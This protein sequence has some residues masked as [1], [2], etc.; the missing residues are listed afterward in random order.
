MNNDLLYQRWCIDLDWYKRNNC[1]FLTLAQSALCLTCR[2][3]LKSE[4]KA[5]EILEMVAICCSKKAHFITRNMPVL[6]SLFR[7]FLKNRNQ[8][9]TLEGIARELG[10]CRGDKVNFSP[11]VLYRLLISD[12]YYGLQP[13]LEEVKLS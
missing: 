8:P 10:R 7:I 9:L 5:S 1:S 6:A 12:R 13:V 4:D 3:Q 11:E 2:K